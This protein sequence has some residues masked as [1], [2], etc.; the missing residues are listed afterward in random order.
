MLKHKWREFFSLAYYHNLVCPEKSNDIFYADMAFARSRCDPFLYQ[1]NRMR[2]LVFEMQHYRIDIEQERGVAETNLF[3]QDEFT[4]YQTLKRL[5]VEEIENALEAHYGELPDDFPIP[6]K[7]AG[8]LVA[9]ARP[10]HH[11]I[12]FRNQLLDRDYE[13]LPARRAAAELKELIYSRERT[14]PSMSRIFVTSRGTSCVCSIQPKLPF[15]HRRA[16]T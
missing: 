8:R 4:A 9:N 11:Y 15:A 12:N 13:V 7:L 10:I 3:R 5:R 1:W 2:S 14:T 6:P 16:A